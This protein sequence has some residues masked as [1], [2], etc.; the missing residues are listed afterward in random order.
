MRILKIDIHSCGDCPFSYW[1]VKSAD[2]RDKGYYCK[3]PDLEY[4]KMIV[5]ENAIWHGDAHLD[6]TLPDWCPLEEMKGD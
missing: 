3:N 2:E 6:F 4:N 5:D 1:D